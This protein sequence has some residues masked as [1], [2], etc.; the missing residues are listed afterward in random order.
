MMGSR[1]AGLRRGVGAGVSAVGVLATGTVA[2]GPVSAAK[3]RP[4]VGHGQPPR[5]Y[6]FWYTGPSN[7]GKPFKWAAP[8]TD[9]EIAPTGP[10]RWHFSTYSLNICW[11]TEKPATEDCAGGPRWVP[12]YAIY[13]GKHRQQGLR[14]DVCGV[15]VRCYSSPGMFKAR[16]RY[17]KPGERSSWLNMCVMRG[18]RG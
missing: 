14:G 8:G 16:D 7:Y 12:P 3:P 6:N 2:A 10:A 15:D 18:P 11:P 13:R 17:C 5:D 1:M 4:P 9:W